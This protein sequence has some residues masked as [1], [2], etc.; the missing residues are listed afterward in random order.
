MENTIV[1]RTITEPTE[2]YWN[3]YNTESFKVSDKLE[4]YKLEYIKRE[5]DINLKNEKYITIDE[6]SNIKRRY[7]RNF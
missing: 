7:I 1:S 6:G 3:G 4:S 2:I 5:D